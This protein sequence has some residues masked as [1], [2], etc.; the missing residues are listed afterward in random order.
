MRVSI[1][2]AGRLFFSVVYLFTWPV[3]LTIEFKRVKSQKTEKTG[4]PTNPAPV[5]SQKMSFIIAIHPF[6]R[7][8]RNARKN[9]TV[10]V[11]VR[12]SVTVGVSLV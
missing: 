12:V 9:I 6:Y 5:S 7:C 8:R 10:T 4:P 11:S 3:E 1:H 2:T